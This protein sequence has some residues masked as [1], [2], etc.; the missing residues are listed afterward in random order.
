[1]SGLLLALTCDR[2]FHSAGPLGFE[3]RDWEGKGATEVLKELSAYRDSLS[4]KAPAEK[5]VRDYQLI[6]ERA[7]FCFKCVATV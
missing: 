3:S 6:K 1:M 2:F 4:A 7:A 5:E